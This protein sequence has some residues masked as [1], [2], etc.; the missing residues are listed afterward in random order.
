MRIKNR[1]QGYILNRTTVF[2][3]LLFGIVFFNVFTYA[4][5]Y[6]SFTVN[7]ALFILCIFIAAPDKS[8]FH[9]MSHEILVWCGM[10]LAVVFVLLAT[11][12]DADIYPFITQNLHFLIGIIL[13]LAVRDQFQNKQHEFLIIAI[14]AVILISSIATYQVLANDVNASRQLAGAATEAERL[15][16]YKKGVG[17]YGYI[18]LLV[19]LNYAL[20]TSLKAKGML[21]L[22][23]AAITCMVINVLVIVISSYS[24]AILIQIVLIGLFL[25]DR[26]SKRKTIVI[27]WGVAM[28][29]F[30][31]RDDIFRYLK[32]LAD[33]MDLYYVSKRMGQLLK[34]DNNDSYDNLARSKLYMKSFETFLQ[35]PFFGN[36]DIGNHS[37]LL[38]ALGKY[39]IF[40]L[41][42]IGYF[43][44]ILRKIAHALANNS[45]TIL[46]GIFFVF[47][48][49]DRIDS[50][51]ILIGL[52]CVVPMFLLSVQTNVEQN[53]ASEMLGDSNEDSAD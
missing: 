4:Q 40:G 47:A 18:Y 25:A 6:Y 26:K 5:I 7:T 39:G 52:L 50:R 35:H 11:S 29:L 36:N 44:H 38:D 15:L 10:V 31:L 9:E 16:Y 1:S 28:V 8:V 53:N 19:F 3:C 51:E 21:P 30:W 17:G 43:I 22:K 33:N 45:V 41:A 12:R 42:Y 46:Y 27:F 32:D 23:V 24:T 20:L 13:F 2:F 49:I 14:L 37:Q 48:C 34:A